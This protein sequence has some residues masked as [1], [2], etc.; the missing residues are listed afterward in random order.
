[1]QGSILYPLNRL[2]QLHPELAKKPL[3]KYSWRQDLL[4]RKI[5]S[6]NVLWN[7]VLHFT[8]LHPSKTFDALK[9]LKGS[10]GKRIQIVHVPVSLLDERRCVYFVGSDRA[11]NNLSEMHTE[12]VFPF[13]RTEYQEAQNVSEAQIEKWKE[14]LQKS[15][16]VLLFSRTR[17]LLYA[18]ELEISGF[19]VEPL[20]I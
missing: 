6:L 3:E 16:P 20:E 8:T 15:E 17:H 7:D 5:P 18:G 9:L 19:T 4:Q 14:N 12:E 13:I 2:K 10:V 1:M 11:R